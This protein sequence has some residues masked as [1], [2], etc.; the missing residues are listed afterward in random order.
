MTFSSQSGASGGEDANTAG[1]TAE[2]AIDG[3]DIRMTDVRMQDDSLTFDCTFTFDGDISEMQK[4][5]E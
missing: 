3:V 1:N 5:M 4:E 2:N